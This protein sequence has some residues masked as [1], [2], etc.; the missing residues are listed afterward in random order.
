MMQIKLPD[1]NDFVVSVTLDGTLYKLHFSW[2]DRVGWSMGI[3]D[4]ND[5]AVLYGIR[6][7][8]NYPLLFRY[9]RPT[10][11]PGELICSLPDNKQDRIERD[12]FV[13]GKAMLV[14]VPEVEVNAAI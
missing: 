4:G 5:R 10:L 12:D 14:Y 8:P 9:R 2:S 3:K 1:L 6:C 13:T 11:P 7:V